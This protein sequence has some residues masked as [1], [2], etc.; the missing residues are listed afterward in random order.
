MDGCPRLAPAYLG[1]K[2]RGAPDFLH[3][4]PNRFACAAFSKESRMKFANA[5]KLD[6]KSGA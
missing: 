4:A 6:R 2:R 5:N 1:R 3:E